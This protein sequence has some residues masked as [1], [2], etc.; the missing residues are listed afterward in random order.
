MADFEDEILTERNEIPE[1]WDD[2]SEDD[3]DVREKRMKRRR[4]HDKLALGSSYYTL[5]EFKE[6]V[7]EYA[8]RRNIKQDR[9]DK[10]KVS[11]VCG[12]GGKY[13]WRIYCSYDIESQ[14]WLLK[15]KYKYQSCTPD[16]KCKLLK[17]PVIARL[18]LD[19][20]RQKAD[21][22]PEEIQ[23]IIKKKWKIVSTRNQCQK[24]RLLALKW[25]EKEYEEQFAHLRGYANEIMVSNQ[26]STAI[27]DTYKIKAGEDVFNG[28]YVCFGIL[29]NTWRGY[30]RPMIRFD[31][32][33]LKRA[34]K[35]LL[36]TAVGH[37]ANNQ[38]YPIAWAV[39]Q[40]ETTDSWL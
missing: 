25:L 16:G 10:E 2:S 32:P 33:F 12:I 11:Y 29:Q 3:I 14:K 1:S 36:L 17:N 22:M 34:V 27:V 30:C 18:F 5:Y 37:D 23:Q 4:S 15:T 31:G 28:F 35:G 7:L 8:L 9:W 39:V 20:L 21:L 6:V 38:I 13:K 40:S 19:K 26:G 24:G